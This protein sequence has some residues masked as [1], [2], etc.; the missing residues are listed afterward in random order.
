MLLSIIIINHGQKHFL[1]KCVN[2]IGKHLSGQFEIIIVDNT[3]DGDEYISGNA[4][5]IKTPNRGFANANNLAVSKAS[6]KFLLFLNADTEFKKDFFPVFKEHLQDTDFG[7]A[8]IGLTYPGGSYQ[9]SYWNENTFFNEIRN[10]KLEE[11]F[12]Q[13][14]LAS[15]DIILSE[16]SPIEVDWV[17]GAAVIIPKD[18]FLETGGFNEEFFLFYED[19]DICK[20]IKQKGYNVLYLPFDGLEHHKGE[21]VNDKFSADTYYY[22]KKSQLL[23]YKLHN[24]LLQR[25][26]LRLYLLIKFGLLSV[27]SGGV[28][29]R[30]F[31]MIIGASND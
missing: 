12:K 4:T 9:L 10:K 14:Y 8:G 23:Y 13:S 18:V 17:S 15:G 7:A 5:I 6:G 31:R 28:N 3:E 26:L 27:T 21:N 29:R 16:N 1:E 2:S 22:S 20:R 25:I 19:A 30:I 11:R 24:G